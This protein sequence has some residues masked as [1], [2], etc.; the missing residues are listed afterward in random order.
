MECGKCPRGQVRL[1]N[2]G[3]RKKET[4]WEL[5]KRYVLPPIYV[6]TM[7]YIPAQIAKCL[8]YSMVLKFFGYCCI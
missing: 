2:A 3:S 8:F 7:V 6:F 1:L 5:G 4:V